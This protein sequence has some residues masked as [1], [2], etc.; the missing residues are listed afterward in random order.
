MS[1]GV[2]YKFCSNCKNRKH[3]DKPMWRS[4]KLAHVTSERKSAREWR[5]ERK[6]GAPMNGKRDRNVS[7]TKDRDGK[8]VRSSISTF[9]AGPKDEATPQNTR[10]RLVRLLHLFSVTADSS[11][12]RPHR[13]DPLLHLPRWTRREQVGALHAIL[14]MTVPPK[15]AVLL[16]MTRPWSI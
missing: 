6:T 3:G 11:T 1:D 7:S 14:T 12:G 15:N 2:E 10:L 9:T 8:H 4:D 5:A 16:R 13:P